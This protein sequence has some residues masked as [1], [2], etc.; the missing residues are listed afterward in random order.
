[1]KKLIENRQ[2]TIN[3][4]KVGNNEIGGRMGYLRA[5]Q[6]LLNKKKTLL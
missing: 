5:S 1:M 2:N 6:N 4:L 3:E